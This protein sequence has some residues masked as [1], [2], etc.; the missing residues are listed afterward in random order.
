[1][2]Q[3][4]G[5][6]ES[7]ENTQSSREVIVAPERGIVPAGQRESL[8]GEGQVEVNENTES[9]ES[10]IASSQQDTQD[11]QTDTASTTGETIISGQDDS[12]EGSG[13]PAVES[14]S[15]PSEVTDESNAM[16]VEEQ[17]LSEDSQQDQESSEPSIREIV[18][19]AKENKQK[20]KEFLDRFHKTDIVVFQ[21]TPAR[22]KKKKLDAIRDRVVKAKM[23]GIITEEDFD[24][25][26]ADINKLYT[27]IPVFSPE[28]SVAPN[29]FKDVL[30]KNINA[31]E[32]TEPENV[33]KPEGLDKVVF[34]RLKKVFEKVFG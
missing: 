18:D 21:N 12:G 14:Q 31:F 4:K 8:V 9:A 23:E 28:D 29:P 2:E 1:Q 33:D 25:L 11:T 26:M 16:D 3:P 5:S 20:R 10:P 17:G 13:E 30:E 32:T 24:L 27:Q 19:K 34:G 15:I 7:T 22:S 6:L